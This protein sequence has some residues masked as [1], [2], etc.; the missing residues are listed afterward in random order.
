MAEKYILINF[1]NFELKNGSNAR[2]FDFD[3]PE[4]VI[5]DHATICR[6]VEV[7]INGGVYKYIEGSHIKAKVLNAQVYSYLKGRKN[8]VDEFNIKGNSKILD[9]I[10]ADSTLLHR[11]FI[12]DRSAEAEH[13]IFVKTQGPGYYYA[14]YILYEN[15]VLNLYFVNLVDGGEFELRVDVIHEGVKSISRIYTK[16]A[17]EKGRAVKVVNVNI[18]KDA[19]GSDSLQSLKSLLLTQD[20]GAV[21]MPLLEVDTNDVKAAHGSSTG[22][23]LPEQIFYLS[24]RG[25]DEKE[26]N[27]ALK[28]A[29]IND[30][31]SKSS[32]R[33]EGMEFFNLEGD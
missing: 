26:I 14:R 10:E 22:R 25:L 17:I 24:S 29:F 33:I 31:I 18:K 27:D 28:F 15:S 30:V 9:I 1:K 23:A 20:A 32:Y 21:N 13:S 7:D 5:S 19:K 3:F 12:I 2:C 16:S 11:F 4:E 6:P 8:M